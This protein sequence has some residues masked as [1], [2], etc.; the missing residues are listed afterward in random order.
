VLT[1][2]TLRAAE[3]LELSHKEL[4]RVIGVSAASLSRLTKSRAIEPE[5]KEGELALILLRIFRS[6]DALV[7]GDRE[8]AR[9]WF[10]ADNLHLGGTPAEL[11][12]RVEGLVAVAEYLDAIRGRL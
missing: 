1:R 8:A 7:G 4:A 9:L 10:H 2:A 12:L 6:L 5:T 11:V 3:A